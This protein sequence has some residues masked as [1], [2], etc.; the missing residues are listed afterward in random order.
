MI[1]LEVE[2]EKEIASC[3]FINNYIFDNISLASINIV[4]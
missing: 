1:D 2:V 4:L 3:E